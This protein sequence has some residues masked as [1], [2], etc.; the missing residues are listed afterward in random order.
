M[1]DDAPLLLEAALPLLEATPPLLEEALPLLEEALPL[2]E[3]TPPLLEEAPPL[4][5]GRPPPL[6]DELLPEGAP[7]DEPPPPAGSAGTHAPDPTSD[8]RASVNRSVRRAGAW[9]L[10][11]VVRSMPADL[12]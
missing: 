11:W 1:P 7:P 2:L 6:D 5:D 3:G 12:Q 10:M 9:W 4:L 8:V